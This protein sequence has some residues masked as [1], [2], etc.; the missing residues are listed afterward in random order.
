[1]TLL[2]NSSRK[3]PTVRISGGSRRVMLKT[4]CA[5]IWRG[6]GAKMKPTAS[7]PM[8]TANR[9]SSS[10]VMPQILT[11]MV[12]QTYRAKPWSRRINWR[13]A[14]AKPTDGTRWIVG[15][16][17]RLTYED[18]VVAG[19]SQAV[20]VL[21]APNA[22]LGHTNDVCG[23]RCGHPHRPLVIDLERD[24]I[25]LIDADDRGVDLQCDLELGLIVDLD[26]DVE[27]DTVGQFGKRLQ[28]VLV[29]RCGDQQDA[30]GAHDP[31]V[32]HVAFA[33]REVLAE[34][35]QG[36]RRPSGLQ[37]GDR[38]AEVWLV[39][40]YGEATCPALLVRLG[41]RSGIET[42]KQVTLGW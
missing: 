36:A 19:T 38:A 7:A 14:T 42:D 22:A 10:L 15:R 34:H 39:G 5:A 17:Q 35:R 33:D 3:T 13:S 41:D 12:A 24:E 23:N 25:A 31:S 29:E 1:M 28:L 6:D 37:I 27:A 2:G 8:A 21:S 26:Q 11:N 4:C 18:R 9:A 16:H 40:Q 30:V 32:E 20:R